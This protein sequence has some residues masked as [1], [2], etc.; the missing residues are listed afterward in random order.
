MVASGKY[1]ISSG[2]LFLAEVVISVESIP[3]DYEIHYALML[4]Q[5]Y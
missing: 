3:V 1:I 4:F 2:L 5:F